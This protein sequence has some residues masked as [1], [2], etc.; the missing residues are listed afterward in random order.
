MKAIGKKMENQLQMK[1]AIILSWP[2]SILYYFLSSEMNSAVVT[3]TQN[4][5]IIMT[6]VLT[7]FLDVG[8]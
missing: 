1:L 5:S 4:E 2:S 6:S 3:W 8:F 7:I